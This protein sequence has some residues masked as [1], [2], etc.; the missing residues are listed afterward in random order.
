MYTAWEIKTKIWGSHRQLPKEEWEINICRLSWYQC[1]FLRNN[2]WSFCRYIMGP[3]SGWWRLGG[4]CQQHLTAPILKCMSAIR[5]DRFTFLMD[6]LPNYIVYTNLTI[7]SIGYLL[8]EDVTSLI[9]F[10]LSKPEIN[11]QHRFIPV[12]SIWNSVILDLSYDDDD[13]NDEVMM[14]M[15]VM[16]MMMMMMIWPV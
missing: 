6:L 11:I 15:K 8:I 13:D 14:M 5:D 1:A 4:K 7:F 12:C 16:M 9:T 3:F 2:L 10:N